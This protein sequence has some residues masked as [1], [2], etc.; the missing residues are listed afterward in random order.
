MRLDK[1]SKGVL[2]FSLSPPVFTHNPY[3]RYLQHAHTLLTPGCDT[4]QMRERICHL[5][6]PGISLPVEKVRYTPGHALIA[7][8]GPS[9]YT[10]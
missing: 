4:L 2:D 3:T 8:S 6:L 7:A 1:D 9:T 5:L 10:Q